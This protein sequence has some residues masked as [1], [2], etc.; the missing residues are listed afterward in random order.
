MHAPR[1]PRGEWAGL[2]NPRGAGGRWQKMDARQRFIEKCQFDPLT[3]CVLW[4]GAQTCGRGHHDPYGAFKYEGRR[5]AAHRW[6]AK[7][8]HGFEIEGLQVDHCCPNIPLPNTLCVEHVRP[9]T[10]EQNRHLQTE[11]RKKFIHLQVGLLT[12]EDVYGPP[13]EA[14]A[15]PLVPFFTPPAW[16]GNRGESDDCPF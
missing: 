9:L 10:G 5:W 1:K 8:I 12:Y 15:D 2:V 16:L 11:R 7:F 4:T 6:A 3:G 14:P 13:P